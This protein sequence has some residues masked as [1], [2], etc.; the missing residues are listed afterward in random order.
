MGVPLA[1]RSPR[2]VPRRTHKSRPEEEQEDIRSR[3]VIILPPPMMRF[4]EIEAKRY[5]EG[6]RDVNYRPVDV[7]RALITAYYEKR[8]VGLMVSPDD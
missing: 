7:V 4:L 8:M 1:E 6:K 2:S 5:S 3:M